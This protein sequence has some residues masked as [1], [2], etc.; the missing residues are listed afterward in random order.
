MSRLIDADKLYQSFLDLQGKLKNRYIDIDDIYH[1]I[2]DAQ[3]E[4]CEDTVSRKA[5]QDMLEN[6]PVTVENKWFNWLQKACIRFGKLPSVQPQKV[7]KWKKIG[8]DNRGRGAIQVCT[9]CDKTYPFKTSYC[10]NCGCKMLEEG[11]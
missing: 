1:V 7:G 8:A 3:T 6:L 10:P 11:E 9:V 2:K 5:V 4:P